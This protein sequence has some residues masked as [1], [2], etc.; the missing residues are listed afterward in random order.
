MSHAN[1]AAMDRLE[2]ERDAL[3]QALRELVADEWRVSPS[4]GPGSE[5]EPIFERCYALLKKY[6]I[7]AGHLAAE[8]SP[9]QQEGV[10]TCGLTNEGSGP[11]GVGP[12]CSVGVFDPKWIEPGAVVLVT[13]ANLGA[14]LR[15]IQR[16]REIG[17]TVVEKITLIDRQLRHAIA[18]R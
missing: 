16:L 1:D 12:T 18:N 5:R 10:A 6:P 14:C 4:W 8:S 11:V 9:P 7:P 3:L 13:A 2:D 15:E 17:E